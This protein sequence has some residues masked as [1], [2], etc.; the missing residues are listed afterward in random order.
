MN[1]TERA[2]VRLP[3][4]TIV[5]VDTTAFATP[6]PVVRFMRGGLEFQGLP[7][8]G[9]ALVDAFAFDGRGRP[10]FRLSEVPTH[11]QLALSEARIFTADGEPV[12]ASG[13]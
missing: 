7:E 12:R 1:R 11:F 3:N 4:G 5:L 2:R 8:L 10:C 13:R 6:N 9:K